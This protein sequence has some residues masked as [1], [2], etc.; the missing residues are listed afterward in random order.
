VQD[1]EIRT[2]S[3]PMMLD[4]DRAKLEGEQQAEHSRVVR[5]YRSLYAAKAL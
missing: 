3:A 5:E 2:V 1:D 4:P